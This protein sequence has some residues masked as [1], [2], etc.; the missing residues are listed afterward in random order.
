MKLKDLYPTLDK[1]ARETLAKASDIDSGYLWQIATRW[2]GKKPSI[3]AIRR[4]AAADAR[5]TI[6]EL[7]SEFTDEPQ[8]ASHA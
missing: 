1:A 6:N 3:G 7:V 4:L 2:R 8:E 5:L